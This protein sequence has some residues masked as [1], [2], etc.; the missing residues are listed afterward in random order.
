MALDNSELLLA[1]EIDEKMQDAQAGINSI[2][3]HMNILIR[4]LEVYDKDWKSRV[5]DYHFVGD[6]ANLEN[7]LAAYQTALEADPL[8][9][10]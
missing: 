10:I 3:D 4:S 2:N 8:D 6:L 9:Y 1:E 7:T 5:N